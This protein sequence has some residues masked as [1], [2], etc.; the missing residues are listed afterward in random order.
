M[1]VA[2]DDVLTYTE[3]T[4]TEVGEGSHFADNLLLSCDQFC[5][6]VKNQDEVIRLFAVLVDKRRFAV[7]GLVFVEF[8]ILIVLSIQ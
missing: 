3:C 7:P 8:K 5:L 6:S 2:G 4:H 1:V